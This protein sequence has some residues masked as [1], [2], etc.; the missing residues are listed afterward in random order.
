M[1]QKED[2][3]QFFIFPTSR[4]EFLSF[5]SDEQLLSRDDVLRLSD[6][7]PSFVDRVELQ[8]ILPPE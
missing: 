3:L 1:S 2:I 7:M 4:L 8:K 5:L 6:T